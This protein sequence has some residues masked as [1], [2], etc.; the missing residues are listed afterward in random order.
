[1]RKIEKDMLEALTKGVTMTK[2]NTQVVINSDGSKDVYLFGNKICHQ[3]RHG[4]RLYNDCGWVTS[5]T[6]S[7]LH[8]LGA[9]VRRCNGVFVRL[10]GKG[11][12]FN[13][14]NG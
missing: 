13:K 14:W 7:R 11:W 12:L 6:A 2:G 1:M 8:A 4:Q 9:N 3:L 10:D 5:T